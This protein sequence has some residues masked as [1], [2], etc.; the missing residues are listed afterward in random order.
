MENYDKFI[1][2][3]EKDLKVKVTPVELP[4]SDYGI[5]V[6]YIIATSEASTNL[7]R[8]DGIRYGGR[9]K[10][11]DLTRLYEKSRSNGF[12]AEVKRRIILGTFALSSGY[13]DAYYEKA[14]KVRTL[15]ADDF[16]NAFKKVDLICIPTTPDSAFKIGE[17]IDDPLKM[18]M[19][20]LL[21]VGTN[22]AGLPGLSLP[23]G[24]DNK[25]DIPLGLQILGSPFSESSVLG[26]A[27]LIHSNL[28][29][30]QETFPEKIG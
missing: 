25:K 15:I 20:D 18:Y 10:S 24:W 5:P 23:F 26:L 3:L 30:S 14:S 28:D 12:G 2:H 19:C 1:S 8:F 11:D 6:Y 13:Y 16:R 7:A 29:R 21:T 9:E 27:H 17:N 4:H 22:L